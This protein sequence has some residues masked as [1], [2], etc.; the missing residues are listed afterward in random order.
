[1]TWVAQWVVTRPFGDLSFPAYGVH[2]GVDLAVPPAAPIPALGPGVVVVDDDNG[3][4]DPAQP[5]TWSG[6][7]VSYRLDSDGATVTCAHLARNTV[8]SGQRVSA[9]QTIGYCGA[10]GAATGPHL[11]L[12]V[13]DILGALIDP[14]VYFEEE[15]M[16]E[17]QIREIAKQETRAVLSQ[18]AW[19][20]DAIDRAVEKA[21]LIASQR[22]GAPVQ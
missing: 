11:H 10:T 7:A 15:A 12:E 6:I 14:L 16:T 4:F 22:L 21:L 8:Y 17:N 18:E 13:R 20:N 9:G 19:L 3:A 2:S 5:Q 1:M